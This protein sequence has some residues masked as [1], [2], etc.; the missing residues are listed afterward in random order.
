MLYRSTR[1]SGFSLQEHWKLNLFDVIFGWKW[2]TKSDLRRKSSVKRFACSQIISTHLRGVV[3]RVSLAFER[4]T[5][6]TAAFFETLPNGKKVLQISN[7]HENHAKKLYCSTQVSGTSGRDA[8]NL[9]LF[10]NFSLK[11]NLEIQTQSKIQQQI[12]CKFSTNFHSLA[13][14]CATTQA[15]VLKVEF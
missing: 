3:Q 14:R 12:F 5:F 8:R 9:I 7:P 2:I 11:I 6:F 1:V 10:P 15:P 13:W 4:Q